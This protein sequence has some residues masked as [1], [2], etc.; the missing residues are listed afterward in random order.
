MK[1]DLIVIGGGPAGLMAAGRAGECLLH[2][3]AGAADSLRPAE[4]GA[5]VLLL[6]KNKH[7]GVKLLLTGK[8][9]CNLTNDI[10][11]KEMVKAF[12][13]PGKFLFSALSRFSAGDTIH[14]FESRGVKIKIEDNQRAFPASDKARDVL[15]ALLDYLRQSKVDIATGAAVKKIVYKNN[16][17]TKIIL[18][19]GREL[20]AGKYL[21][22]TGGRSYPL[23]GSTGDGYLW[24]TALGHKIIKPLPALTPVIVKNKFVRELEGVSL[25]EACFTLK[26]DG[27][28]IDSRI[29]EAIFTANGLSGPAILAMSGRIARSLPGI[30]LVIDFFPAED[31]SELDSKLQKLFAANSNRQVKNTLIGFLPPKLIA[32]LLKMIQI[33]PETKINRITRSDRRNLLKLIKAFELEVENVGNFDKAMMTAGGVDLKEVDQATMRSKLIGNLFLAGEIL[34]IDGPT[35]GFNLQMCWSTGRL[36]GESAAKIGV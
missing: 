33:A 27:Q 22:A 21:I 25:A 29:G 5:R 3:P 19:D 24:L 9:R 2:E 6:E 8:E 26:K 16:L 34:D 35:G 15:E 14:F 10:S 17:I 13:P 23:T 1:Y 11:V 30:K 28:S 31:I 12:G 4:E 36:A 18:T 32:V 20:S 7:L